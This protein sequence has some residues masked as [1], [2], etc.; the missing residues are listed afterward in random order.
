VDNTVVSK[1][2]QY[3]T[4]SVNYCSFRDVVCTK[5]VYWCGRAIVMTMSRYAPLPYTANHGRNVWL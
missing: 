3:K 2:M 1:V 4:N 5:L